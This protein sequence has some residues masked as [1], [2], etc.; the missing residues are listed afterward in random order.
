MSAAIAASAP[1]FAALLWVAALL[2]DPGPLAPLSVLLVGI[3]LLAP[4]TTALIG[5]VVI[6]ARWAWRLGLIV[7][8]LCAVLAVVR[9][10]DFIWVIALSVTGL[11]LV[12][13]LSPPVARSLRRLPVAT[14]PPIRAVL[15]PLTLIVFPYTLGL[16]AGDEPNLATVIIGVGAP[17]CALWFARVFPLGLLAVRVIWPALAVGLAFAQTPAPA[18]A[19]A[20]GGAVLAFMAWHPSVKVAFHPPREGGTSHAIP[21]ELAPREVLDTAQLDDRGRPRG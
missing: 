5:V 8:G 20:V 15:I 19:S 14:G 13:I 2:L 4:A 18:T 11:A 12:A 1:L 9:P 7:V 3:G 10:I 21:P 17:L 16:A 6:G